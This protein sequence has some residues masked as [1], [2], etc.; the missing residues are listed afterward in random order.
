MFG[1]GEGYKHTLTQ[2]RD[3]HTIIL[4]GEGACLEGHDV[5]EQDAHPGLGPV[6][7]ALAERD[8]GPRRAGEGG[9]LPAG[10]GG[11]ERGEAEPAGGEDRGDGGGGA[12]E[13]EAGLLAGGGRGERG[14]VAAEV[15]GAVG[16]GYAVDGVDVVRGG[17]GRALEEGPHL[18]PPCRSAC[19]LTLVAARRRER[20]A[21]WRREFC[22]K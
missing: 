14:A 5:A 2:L 18:G 22:G 3:R 16:V 6:G 8:D 10:G 17:R 15:G 11:G 21:G 4:E 9:S 7:P 12:A 19:K 1:C 13:E 20:D